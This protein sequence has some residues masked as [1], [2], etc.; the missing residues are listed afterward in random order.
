MWNLSFTP[1]EV[2]EARVLTRLPDALR[3]PVRSDW[4]D[5]NKPGH[6]VDCFLE[7]PCFDTAGNL[8][9]TDIPHGR[10]FRV[11]AHLQW[12]CVADYGG[13]PNGLAR[14]ADGSIW[15]ADYR[16]G[17][18]RLDT[19]TGAIR[20]VLGHRNSEAFKGVND[21]CFD[22]QGRL[23]FTDQGQTGLHDPTG[24]VYR[25]SPDSGRLDLLLAHAPSPN[26]LALSAD[27]LL[28]FLAV[29]RANQVWRAPLLADGSIS[30]MGAF[31]TFFGTSGPDGLALDAQGRLV[32][33]HA[34][35]G[36]AFV[37]NARGEVTHV[38]RSPV[39]ATVTNVA[40]RP[41][42]NELVMTESAT[43]SL[44]VA[45]LPGAGLPLFGHM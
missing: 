40:F 22:A 35:L 23:Y 14:H 42:T 32:V 9:V 26:G 33:A 2:I 3:R 12:H 43:G 7:G 18:L 8:Y 31:Q 45:T 41:G 25:F 34:S 30:K 29:T 27:G 24:R 38:V 44:L 15:I 10:I 20:T 5:A 11:D 16:R 6:V 4:A 17:I 36:G 28:L 13:W 1:P 39:G 21:L 19:E 37:L